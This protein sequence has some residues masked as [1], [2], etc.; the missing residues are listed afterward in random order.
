MYL[1]NVTHI[2]FHLRKYPT[3]I[4]Y[5]LVIYSYDEINVTNSSFHSFYLDNTF[6]IDMSITRK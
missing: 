2:K 5:K 3:N 4:N 1:I 6:Y